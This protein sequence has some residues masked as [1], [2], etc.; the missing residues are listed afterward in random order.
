MSIPLLNNE[1]HL[2]WTNL[3]GKISK[4]EGNLSLSIRWANAECIRGLKSPPLSSVIWAFVLHCPHF[5]P[6]LFLLKLSET[7]L[8]CTPTPNQKLSAF[9]SV[10]S[11]D[12]I[13]EGLP[14][15]QRAC[16]GWREPDVASE[17]PLYLSHSGIEG[18]KEEGGAGKRE[19]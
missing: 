8:L 6:L 2:L 11:P 4:K 17:L 5:L 14:L 1:Y 9:P 18:R 7:P 12:L 13:R 10:S 15:A 16:E 3:W 19:G